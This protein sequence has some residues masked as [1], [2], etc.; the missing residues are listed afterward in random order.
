MPT[1]R[2]TLD[3]LARIRR[4]TGKQ[5][6]E[7]EKELANLSPKAQQEFGRLLCDLQFERDKDVRNAQLFPWR[8]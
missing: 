4:N 5:Y 6:P 3:I 8:R 7:L 1:T 2:T